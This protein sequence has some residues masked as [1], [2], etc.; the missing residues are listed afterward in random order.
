MSEGTVTLRVAAAVPCTAAE[1]PFLR[2]AL[3]VQGCSL[4]C[5]GCCNPE[6]FAAEGGARVAVERLAAE[7]RA[8][9]DA[10]ALE[11]LSVLG[12]EPGEQADAVAALCREARALG[13]GV[14]LFSG[15]T[16]AELAARPGGGALLA[17]VDTLVDGRFDARRREPAE[18]RRFVG[19]TNQ[20]LVHLTPRYAEPALWRG[21]A[22]VELRIGREGEL[23][24][25]GAP[26]LVRRVL[27]GLQDAPR[28]APP[29]AGGHSSRKLR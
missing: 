7:L 1:G 14:L 23:S 24:A 29:E 13:L 10:H 17:A 20:R 21:P 8:A 16:H 18:G 26:E 27:R 9:R 6:L 19:S 28:L 25:H 2:F 12:G 15:Y 22:G 11:G 4:R 3:W 5:P